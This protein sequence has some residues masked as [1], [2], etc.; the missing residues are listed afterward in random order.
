MN[1]SPFWVAWQNVPESPAVA[2]AHSLVV[3]ENADES[4]AAVPPSRWSSTCRRCLCMPQENGTSRDVSLLMCHWCSRKIPCS[5]V[6][7]CKSTHIIFFVYLLWCKCGYSSSSEGLVAT[8]VFQNC[9]Q[10]LSCL[11]AHPKFFQGHSFTCAITEDG[12]KGHWEI[13]DVTGQCLHQPWTAPAVAC[14]SCGDRGWSCTL[15][16]V[17]PWDSSWGRGQE[18]SVVVREGIGH[19]TDRAWDGD[20]L[21]TA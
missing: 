11:T 10:K 9:F 15:C 4:P 1:L 17:L 3:L 2:G 6:F 16:E 7:L 18:P 14:A 12:D 5:N 19:P 8:W 13:F 21:E 20:L